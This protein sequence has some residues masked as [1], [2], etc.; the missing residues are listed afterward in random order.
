MKAGFIT[1]VIKNVFVVVAL[2]T[3]LPLFLLVGSVMALCTLLFV[4]FMSL[5][6]FTGHKQRFQGL[7]I[8]GR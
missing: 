2:N 4:F 6:D 5:D 3:E 1:Q 8:N 7:C